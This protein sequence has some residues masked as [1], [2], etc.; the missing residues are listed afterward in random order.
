[1]FYIESY[2]RKIILPL[3]ILLLFHVPLNEDQSSP[4]AKAG[5]IL[6]FLFEIILVCHSLNVTRI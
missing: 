2:F 5:P 3:E 6:A 4:L 1:M